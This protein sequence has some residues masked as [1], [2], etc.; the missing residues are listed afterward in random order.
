MLTAIFIITTII[1]AKG[2]FKQT[3]FANAMM[4]YESLRAYLEHG[5]CPFGLGWLKK[6]A[7]NRAFYIPTLTFY[8][9]VTQAAGFRKEVTP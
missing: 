6:N 2:W 9:W 7:H 3:I 5:S 8:L 4:V 1:C